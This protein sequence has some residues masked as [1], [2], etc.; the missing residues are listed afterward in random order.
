MYGPG[1][2]IDPDSETYDI[3]PGDSVWLN[4]GAFATELDTGQVHEIS[5]ISDNSNGNISLSIEGGDLSGEELVPSSAASDPALVIKEILP[6]THDTYDSD[7]TLYLDTDE[8]LIPGT[9]TII[10]TYSLDATDQEFFMFT[11]DTRMT[12]TL[13]TDPSHYSGTATS[14]SVPTSGRVN[15]THHSYGWIIDWGDDS[16]LQTAAGT[17]SSPNA[18]IS[19]DYASSNGAGEYTITIL[20]NGVATNGWFNAFGFLTISLAQGV[21]FSERT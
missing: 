12:D 19:H 3:S 6:A 11:I 9:Y 10:L 20:S 2:E 13:D 5:V 16:P 4:F 21:R 7:Y 18:G 8:S 17:G 14:F 1:L 15:N